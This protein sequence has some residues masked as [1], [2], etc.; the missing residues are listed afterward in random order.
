MEVCSVG[1]EV[2]LGDLDSVLVNKY[3]DV[4]ARVRPC[5]EREVDPPSSTETRDKLASV[6]INPRRISLQTKLAGVEQ[7]VVRDH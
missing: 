2:G 7:L 5:H 4:F 3:V 6:D 1:V